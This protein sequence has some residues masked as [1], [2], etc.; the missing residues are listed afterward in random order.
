MKAD[1]KMSNAGLQVRTGQLL[2]LEEM[3]VLDGHVMVERRAGREV[4]ATNS[5]KV[6]Q[7]PRSAD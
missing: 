1:P 5:G 7:L 3:E 6:F 4:E 2:Q